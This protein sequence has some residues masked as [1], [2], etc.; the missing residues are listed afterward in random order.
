MDVSVVVGIILFTTW[1]GHIRRLVTI[2]AFE[3]LVSFNQIINDN[4]NNR[5]TFYLLIEHCAPTRAL[6]NWTK[7]YWREWFCFHLL[8]ICRS[9]LRRLI[10]SWNELGLS[11]SVLAVP[12]K[13]CRNKYAESFLVKIR[14]I[15]S[16]KF[17]EGL[18]IQQ[19]ANLLTEVCLFSL[20]LRHST[21]LS[22]NGSGI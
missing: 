16:R 15:E 10:V 1:D 8:P 19:I 9:K 20:I 2:D 6:W 5:S 22:K 18:L 3:W 12:K 7:V 17:N 13:L 14:G 11:V 21:E 4:L